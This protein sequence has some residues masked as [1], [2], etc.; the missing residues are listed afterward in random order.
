MGKHVI[1][2][3]G[4][5][6]GLECAGQLAR[7][8][9]RVTVLEKSGSPGG[10][11]ADWY[12][13]FPDRR[14]GSEVTDYVYEFASHP[15]IGII[16]G[17][18]VLAVSKNGEGFLVQTAGNETMKADAVVVA[19]GFDLFDA[20]KKE[21][22][23]YGIYENVITSADLEVMFHN[24]RILTTHGVAPVRVGIIHCVGS[25]DEKAG[26]FHCSKVCCVTAVKQAIEIKEHLP[27]AQV[28]CFYMDLR[29]FGPYYEELYRESQEKWNVNYIRGKVSEVGETI[30]RRLVVK[31]EDTLAGRPLK[32]EIDLLVLM[33]GMEMSKGGAAIARS[34]GLETGPNRFFKS[35]DNH[36]GSNES[37]IDGIF[38][39][40]TCVAPMNITDSVSHARAAAVSVAAYLKSKAD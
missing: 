3:G 24:G 17:T 15:S 26:N 27:S 19:T 9:N 36:Y 4:G 12:Q 34:S 8:G 25:R 30:N 2:I 23:G 10:H 11:I 16:T 5:V 21:E 18:T 33:T 22:Y 1:V 13:L 40:G 32:M 29:M 35:R 28:F 7:S 37:N 14:K 6:A 20:T 39:A 31:V 38:Y